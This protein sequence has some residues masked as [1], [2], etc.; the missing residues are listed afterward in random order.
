MIS[1]KVLEELGFEMVGVDD[2]T[3]G[4]YYS[5]NIGDINFHSDLSVDFE[6]S[7]IVNMLHSE[8]LEIVDEADL[9][10]LI[11]ILKRSTK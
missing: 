9:I 2:S 5:L 1:K 11:G 4:Y 7:F 10:V 6:G 3:Y 8:T